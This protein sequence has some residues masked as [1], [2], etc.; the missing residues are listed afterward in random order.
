VPGVS[1]VPVAAGCAFLAFDQGRGLA[2]FEVAVP[3]RLQAGDIA[4]THRKELTAIC[5]QIRALAPLS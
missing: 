2:D 5:R 3:D 4:S 1:I